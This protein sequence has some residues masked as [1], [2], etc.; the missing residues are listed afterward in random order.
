MPDYKKEL[1]NLKKNIELS[2]TK[3]L[4][5]ELRHLELNFKEMKIEKL[6]YS[7]KKNTQLLD[8]KLNLLWRVFIEVPVV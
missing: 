4:K 1:I 8:K 5:K 3:K 2:E 7:R 6:Y